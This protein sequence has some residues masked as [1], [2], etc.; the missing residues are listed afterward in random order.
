MDRIA[1]V[2]QELFWGIP[3]MLLLLGVGI[4]LTVL[5]GAPQFRQFG[6]ICREA[7]R[8]LRT[9]PEKGTVSPFRAMCTALAASVGTGNIAGV[10][11]AIALGGPGA[12]FWMWVSAA[13]GMCTKLT[14]VTLAVRYRRRSA[15]GERIGGP[16][17]YIEDGL[18]R[19]FRWLA[20]IFSAAGVLASAG[21]GVLTQ[22]NTVAG[23]VCA[24]IDGFTAVTDGLRRTVVLLT[25]IGCAAVS[26]WILLGGV[27]RL[28]EAC[29]GLVPF[30]AILYLGLALGVIFWRITELPAAISAIFRCAFRPEAM[31]GGGV[32]VTAR[33]A[34]TA[35]IGRGVFSN[36]AGVGS[37]PIAYAAADG[38]DPV[39]QGIFGVI[40]VFVDT[41]LIC[42]A[43]AFVILLGVGTESIPYGRA[44]SA[45]LAVRGLSAVWGNRI[46]G[47]LTAVCLTL[48]AFSTCLTWA[49][50]GCRCAEYLFGERIR[51]PFLIFYCICMIPCAAVGTE[52]AW[53]LAGAVNGLMAL[54]NLAA[55]LLLAP[56]AA[57][58]IR[59]YFRTHSENLEVSAS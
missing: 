9:K 3:V 58:M 5:C 24:A 49:L 52:P 12:V 17:Y 2:L 27:G 55:L 6:R 38:D 10:A 54:P 57:A 43:T 7:W 14:E 36:E 59:I 16:M 26:A 22:V 56:E 29:A 4:R 11:G 50:Y 47:V 33:S 51:K 18:G 39:G 15:A 46:P 37:A 23:T 1:D 31:L 35:G 44:A 19:R 53:E 13:F 20:V 34:M 40:E 25:G 42:T 48:F 32:G 30:M 45:E 21:T 8:K 41:G 28:A